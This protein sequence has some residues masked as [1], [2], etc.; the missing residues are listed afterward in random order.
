V[1]SKQ[2]WFSP[3]TS[4]RKFHRL[5]AISFRN[6][7]CR[8]ASAMGPRYVN[9][10]VPATSTMGWPRAWTYSA[11]ARRRPNPE[12]VGAPLFKRT[13]TS[14]PWKSVVATVT[15]QAIQNESVLAL[16]HR[17]LSLEKPIRLRVAVSID[18][19]MG[20][21]GYHSPRNQTNISRCLKKF[22]PAEVIPGSHCAFRRADVR[23]MTWRSFRT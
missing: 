4:G 22:S 9:R 7:E 23:Q 21:M 3:F 16:R 17:Y 20:R 1:H 2:V 12:A 13:A 10:M 6:E 18:N 11:K 8:A 15:D 19:V 14:A 5:T